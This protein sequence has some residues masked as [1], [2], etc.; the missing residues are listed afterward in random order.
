MHTILMVLLA[1]PLP[2]TERV[3]SAQRAFK[4]LDEVTILAYVIVLGVIV[5]AI[6]I[7]ANAYKFWLRNKQGG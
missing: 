3:L 2:P 4:K 5:V 1:T 6:V 7:L